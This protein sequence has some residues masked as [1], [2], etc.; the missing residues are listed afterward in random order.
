MMPDLLTP[1]VTF[2]PA[3]GA[4]PETT[5]WASFLTGE[6]LTVGLLSKT[7]YNYPTREWLETLVTDDVFSGV[8]LGDAQP[9]VQA[10][11]ALLQAWTESVRGGLSDSALDDVRADCTR[12]MIGP[13]RVLAP[14]WESV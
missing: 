2:A 6:L 9:D 4:Q 11:L 10:G 8:P 5:D 14:P 7:L 13:D 12:L 1:N 3:N